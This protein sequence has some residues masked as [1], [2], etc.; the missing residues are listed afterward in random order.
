[1]LTLSI[2]GP[3]PQKW[4]IND[5]P[6]V[7]SVPT[8]ELGEITYYFGQFFPKTAIKRTELKREEDQSP[9]WSHWIHQCTRCDLVFHVTRNMMHFINVLAIS[10]CSWL[11]M[12]PQTAPVYMI[13]TVATL[14]QGYIFSG[15][16]DSVHSRDACMTGGMLGRR[17]GHCSGWYAWNAFFF[18]HASCLKEG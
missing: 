8:A 11:D 15:D 7:K 14:W 13:V 17:D 1:M 5:F 2:N 10:T 12:M 4:R 3:L 18:I 16:C 6:N 9:I